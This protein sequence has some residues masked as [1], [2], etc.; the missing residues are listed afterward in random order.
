MSMWKC[1]ALNFSVGE[2]PQRKRKIA[3]K[4]TENSLISVLVTVE[5]APISVTNVSFDVTAETELSEF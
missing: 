1:L 5:M 3:R 4:C 2:L